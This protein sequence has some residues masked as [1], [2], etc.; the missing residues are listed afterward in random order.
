VAGN[1]CSLGCKATCDRPSVDDDDPCRT[2]SGCP[3]PCSCWVCAHSTGA[4]STSIQ[5]CGL[6]GSSLVG[7]VGEGGAVDKGV[8]GDGGEVHEFDAKSSFALS[9]SRAGPR[10]I[11]SSGAR[12]ARSE[13]ADGE[14][15]SGDMRP[16]ATTTSILLRVDSFDRGEDLAAGLDGWAAPALVLR[17]FAGCTPASISFL[18]LRG[19]AAMVT[20]ISSSDDD[21]CGCCVGR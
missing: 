17:R 8:S 15:G 13:K 18:F 12:W 14:D 19:V 6:D 2:G 21:W 11:M 9:E 4:P 10:S 16:W 3:G 20:G 1:C 5:S 7:E